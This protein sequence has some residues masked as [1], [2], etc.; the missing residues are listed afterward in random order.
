[1]EPLR[2]RLANGSLDETLSRIYGKNPESLKQARTKLGSLVDQFGEMTSLPNPS[3]YTA[4]GRTELGGNHTDHQHGRVL[5]GSV[6]METVACAA[7][8]DTSS[9]KVISAQYP[10]DRV[11]I[12]DLEP[13]PEEE[14]KSVALVRGIARAL[15]DRGHQLGGVTILTRSGVPSGSGLSSSAAFEVL[16]ANVLNHLFC[17]DQVD[18]VEIA[19]IGQ[20]AENV[21]FGKPSGLMDQMACSVGGIIGIDFGDPHSPKVQPVDFDMDAAGYALCI[22]D[23]G[24]DHADLTDEYAAVTEEMGAVSALFGKEYL[25]QVDAKEFWKD[26]AR[27]RKQAGDRA[28]ARAAH[29]FA[30][31]CRVDQQISSLK[32]GDVSGFLELVRLSGESSG[33]FLQNLRAEGSADQSVVLTIALANHLLNGHGAVRVHGGGFAGTVQAYV[34]IGEAEAFKQSVDAVMGEGRCTIVHIRPVGGAFIA[35]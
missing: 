21:Y 23:S 34:P 13:R 19:Q 8:N 16:I 11:H 6:D 12:D 32:Q 26:L 31:D 2:T 15:Q 28:A 24:A 10:E 9:I 4:A 5:A 27:V 33:I 1:M 22:I 20:Y 18:S 14:G 3:L 17:A 7:L 29:F 25:R 30:E 35:E